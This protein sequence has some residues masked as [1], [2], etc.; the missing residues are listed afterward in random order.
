MYNE[1]EM[2]SNCCGSHPTWQFA[3]ETGRCPDCKEL[4]VYITRNEFNETDKTIFTEEL[5]NRNT[6]EVNFLNEK[7]ITS[8]GAMTAKEILDHL[9]YQSYATQ[10][11]LGVSAET[12]VRWYD[13]AKQFE[14]KF[15]NELKKSH[16]G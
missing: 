15:I 6:H 10:R 7:I 11:Y 3:A 5:F 16:N 8:E 12:L 13:N 14:E 4:C 1:N 9:S 2:V